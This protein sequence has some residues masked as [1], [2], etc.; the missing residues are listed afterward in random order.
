MQTRIHSW[1]AAALLLLGL[2]AA[3][4]EV[5]LELRLKNTIVLHMEAIEAELT[6][7]NDSGEVLVLGGGEKSVPLF[8]DI[9]TDPT[10]L[11]RRTDEPL[12]KEP[13]E[14]LAGQTVRLNFDLLRLYEIRKIGNY[15][16]KAAI[17]LHGENLNSNRV[18]LDVVPGLDVGT[19]RIRPPGT[20]DK[21]ITYALRTLLRDRR[22][23]LLVRVDDEAEELCYGVFD[24]GGVMKNFRPQVKA[25]A[26]G[27]VHLLHQAAPTRFMHTVFSPDQ[28][29]INTE[30]FTGTPATIGLAMIE[31]GEV[32]V[33]GGQIYR[34]DPYVAPS[35]GVERMRQGVQ[36]PQLPPKRRTEDR[37]PR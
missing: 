3:R 28:R 25:D 7:R 36:P 23:H 17:E 12:L 31:G 6:V 11:A 33:E 26:D 19:V 29:V 27:Y 5:V 8:F 21:R 15:K 18:F 1:V 9:E 2:G 30:F 10:V 35:E 13:V 4:A 20:T 24:L 14:I 22:E 32:R 16:M 37:K 34:G